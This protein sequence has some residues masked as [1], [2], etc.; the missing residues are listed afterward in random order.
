MKPAQSAKLAFVFPGQGSQSLGMLSS[1]SG[2]KILQDTFKEA[3]EVLGYDLWELTQKG[4]EDKLNQTEY[5]QPALLTAEYALWR[6]C[7]KTHLYDVLLADSDANPSAQK[8]EDGLVFAGHSLGEY[9]AL[10]CAK[11]L[12]FSSAVALVRERGICMQQAVQEGVGTMAAILGLEDETVNALCLEAS[13]QSQGAIVS[14]A[15]FNAPGQVVIAGETEA[16]NR[17][18][19]LAKEKGAK[20]AIALKVS[21]PSHCALMKPAAE[22]F[23]SI[24]E[25]IMFETPEKTV[26]HNVDVSAHQTAA[27]I[28]S[29]LIAQLYSPVRWVESMQKM[30]AMGVQTIIECGP[31]AVLTG[32]NKRIVP[33][34]TVQSVTTVLQQSVV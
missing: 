19:E 32:L 24:L 12:D 4:P 7:Q 33:E 27:E 14:A 20:R 34:L 30:Q 31:A 3:S 17:A 15:N 5:T 16:V 9:T 18:I 8:L 26:I 2:S 23:A 10:V 1:F 25:Q 28:R 6:I 21:V 22:R 11:S 29:A 13:R